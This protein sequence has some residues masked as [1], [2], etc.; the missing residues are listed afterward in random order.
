MESRRDILQAD[1]GPDVSQVYVSSLNKNYLIGYSTGKLEVRN[2]TNLEISEVYCD[3]GNIIE[4]A[5]DDLSF[6]VVSNAES[7]LIH[8]NTNKNKKTY[9]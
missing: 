6:I 4:I 3:L 8:I 1:C 5:S 2:S 9:L 7:E